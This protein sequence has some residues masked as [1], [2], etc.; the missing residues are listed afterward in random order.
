MWETVAAVTLPAAAPVQD[1]G[2]F[3]SAVGGGSGARGV[4][5]FSGFSVT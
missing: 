2:I 1:V 3:M 5:G 4:A